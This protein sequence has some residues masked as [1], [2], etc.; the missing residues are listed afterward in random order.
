MFLKIKS[1]HTLA[2]DDFWMLC[3]MN[4]PLRT[5]NPPF[6]A[7]NLMYRAFC[8]RAHPTWVFVVSRPKSSNGNTADVSIDV[9]KYRHTLAGDGFNYLLRPGTFACFSSEC[10]IVRQTLF[11]FCPVSEALL[12]PMC[13]SELLCLKLLQHA[14]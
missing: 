4:A 5:R 11:F 14:C 1:R 2:G 6:P 8:P 13:P 12:P 9:F 3:Y 10:N 7:Y